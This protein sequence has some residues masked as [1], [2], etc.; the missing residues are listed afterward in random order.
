MPQHCNGPTGAQ[1]VGTA[2]ARLLAGDRP[3]FSLTTGGCHLP[4]DLHFRRLVRHL[5]RLGPRTVGELLLDETANP[6]RLLIRL[7]GFARWSPRQ[8]AEL[9][10]RDWVDLRPRRVA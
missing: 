3:H 2:A 8:I 4:A 10:C 6:E 5:H 7:E 9:G 1:P